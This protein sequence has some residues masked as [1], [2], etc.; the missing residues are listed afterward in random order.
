MEQE[1]PAG[2]KP[3]FGCGGKSKKRKKKDTGT[4]ACRN[5]ICS[6]FFSEFRHEK[7]CG[8]GSFE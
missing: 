2:S 5:S 4:T 3:V 8:E 1:V 6:V 7:C